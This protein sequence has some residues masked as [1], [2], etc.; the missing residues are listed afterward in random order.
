VSDDE[1]VVARLREMDVA[2]VHEA[3]GRHG[4]LAASIRPIQQGVTIAGPALTAACQPG[5]N[6]AIHRAVATAPAGSVLVVA[7]G[8]HVAG[9]W[10]EILAVAAQHRGIVGLVID[11][12][13]RDTAA[14]RRRGFPVWSA[15]VS[16]HGT[17]KSDPGQVDTPVSVGGVI[18]RPGDYV[19]ADDDGVVVVARERVA[20]VL[21]AADARAA[22]EERIM[23]ALA[24][25]SGTTIELMG[26][27][28]AAARA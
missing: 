10:G 13:A 2:T 12:G 25:G 3:A 27:S 14:L 11:G 23:S 19:L 15:G 16:V 22:K 26:L 9:Y 8:G 28:E 6:L 4:N 18:V 1:V 7:A 5:D 24:D 17:V 21:D 20:E